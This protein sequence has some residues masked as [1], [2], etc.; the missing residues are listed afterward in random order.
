MPKRVATALAL[1]V[2]GI[3]A[4]FFGGIPYLIFVGFLIT[5]AA[6]EYAEM[7]RA[8]GS[9]PANWLVVAGVLALL[10]TRFYHSEAS[11]PVLTAGV[12]L[13]MAYH[14]VD[15]ERGADHAG[16]DFSVSLGALVYLGWVGAY[17]L[18]LRQLDLGG[19]WVLFVLPCVW[20][21]DT[22]AFMLGAAYGKHRMSPRLSP[23]KTWEGFAAG[24][25]TSMLVGGFLAWAYSTWGPLGLPIW[26][27]ALFGL[28][29]G[30]LSP[31]GDLGESMLK[32]QAGLKDS[33]DIFPGHGGAFDRIDSWIWAGVL[34]YYFIIWFI[35]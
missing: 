22:G 4:L 19:W 33:G 2:I 20:G 6:W 9:R 32:R 13:L 35:R 7:F 12:L 28:F 23:K 26:E 3:P 14:L 11:L 34:G 8:A 1:L 15:F 5:A 24:A 18:D 29:V 25:F 10:V 30:L 21:A 31:L 16:L 27:G 17:L